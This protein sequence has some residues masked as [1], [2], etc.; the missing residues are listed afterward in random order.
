MAVAC[1]LIRNLFRQLNAASCLAID[2]MQHFQDAVAHDVTER[3]S[4]SI[5]KG[6]LTGLGRPCQL[7][8]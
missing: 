2:V 1:F 8:P 4:C 5:C 6:D 7:Y 3:F